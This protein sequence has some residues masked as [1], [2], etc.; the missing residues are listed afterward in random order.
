[1]Q[2]TTNAIVLFIRFLVHSLLNRNMKK[3]LF[4]AVVMMTLMCACNDSNKF[5]VSGTVDGAGDTTVLYLETS[6]NG[7]WHLVD[8]AKTDDGKF[9]FKEDAIEYPNIYRLV[10]G[11]DAIYFPIDSIDQ[12]EIKTDLKHFDENYTIGGSKN[13]ETMMKFD[14]ELAQ[15]IKKN[16]FSSEAFM[17]WKNET[18]RMLVNDLK[19]IVSYYIVNKYI[20]DQ[21]LYNPEDNSDFKIIGAVTNAFSTY[22]PNDPRTQY[23]VETYK[24]KLRIR[25]A[26]NG[27]MSRDTIQASQ[28]GVLDFTLMD[29]SGKMR[30]FKEVCSHGKVV[31]LNFTLQSGSFSPT[32]N[33]LLNDV[34]N[35]YQSK[36]LEIYQ[37]SFD[38][39]EASW[40]QAV[41][42]LPWIVTRDT[43]GATTAMR[44]NVTEIPMIYII[45]RSGDI[46]G[47]V[48]N[49][50]LL[51]DTLKKYF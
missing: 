26:A 46:V 48:E 50:D 47:R 4:L 31:I 3:L 23:L 1:M 30:S 9:A 49:I 5:K 32:L 41:A 38:D 33:K 51:E 45:N 37:V 25:R 18:S 20:G 34:Y 44:Y 14:K 28:T 19:S 27:N 42:R 24:D 6:Y 35:K 21:P 22:R 43:N 16:D 40:M 2:G 12:I 8:S 7:M 36:G 15:F 39:D 13:A 11:A 17:K 29:K 10:Y